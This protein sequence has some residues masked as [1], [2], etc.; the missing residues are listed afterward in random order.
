M[1]STGASLALAW[2]DRKPALAG[3]VKPGTAD[4]DPNPFAEWIRE[5]GSPPGTSTAGV[6]RP[7]PWCVVAGV[8][9]PLPD[10][11]GEPPAAPEPPVPPPPAVPPP[12]PPDPL[13]P[14]PPGGTTAWPCGAASWRALSRG[15]E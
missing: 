8:D 12:V 13:P 3:A 6:A 9:P 10:A 5:P 4:E 7:F 1:A 15:I 14:P 11:V 2:T